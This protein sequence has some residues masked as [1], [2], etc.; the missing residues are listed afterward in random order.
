GA[1]DGA[2]VD[3]VAIRRST[4]CCQPRPQLVLDDLTG[5]IAGYIVEYELVRCLVVRDQPAGV[6]PQLL[7][8]EAG[9]LAWRHD[10]D[11]ALPVGRVRHAQ[12][13]TVGHIGV[14]GERVLHFDRVH[15]HPTGDDHVLDSV[16]ECDATVRLDG[17]EVAGVQ[18]PVT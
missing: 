12:H 11:D 6:F 9:A 16:D 5:G 7:E 17:G 15:V 10:C 18:P 4:L 2:P 13:G 14:C 1:D 8:C 3:R